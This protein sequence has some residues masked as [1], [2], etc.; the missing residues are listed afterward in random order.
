MED[1]R[2]IYFDLVKNLYPYIECYEDLDKS[3]SL[4][5]M[6]YNLIEISKNNLNPIDDKEDLNKVLTLIDLFQG[7]GIKPTTI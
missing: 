6:L 2:N 5:E 3:I 4:N 1:I 7:L